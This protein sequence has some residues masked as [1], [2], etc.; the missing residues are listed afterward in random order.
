MY[1]CTFFLGII[2][3]LYMNKY[4]FEL[5]LIYYF[6]VSLPKYTDNCTS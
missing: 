6:Y 3:K 2:F 5:P 4:F 1:M